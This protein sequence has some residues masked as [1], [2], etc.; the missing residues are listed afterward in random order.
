MAQKQTIDAMWDDSPVDVSTE[1]NFIWSITA[2]YNYFYDEIS[3]LGADELKGLHDAI[4]KLD[5]VS[6]SPQPQN[7]DDHQMIFESLNSTGLDLEPSDK[8]RN[9]VLMGLKSKQQEKFYRMYWE[10]LENTVR[11]DEMNKFIRYYLA[12]KTRKLFNESKLYFEFKY[13]Q[14]SSGISIESILQDMLEFAG[15]YQII[16]EPSAVRAKYTDT[17]RRINR[18]DMKTCIPLMMD[19]FKALHD[20]DISEDE[21][22]DALKIIENYIVRREICSLPTNALNKVFVQMGADIERDIDADGVTYF[23]AFRYQILK[24][25]GKAG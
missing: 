11:R 17:L 7:G 5:I 8:I 15:Y 2:N 23:D 14:Q 16:S 12:V 9:F 18:L 4:T 3:K 22:C 24:R 6:I 1:V 20:T 19:L 21:L 25:T 13:Y 10:P